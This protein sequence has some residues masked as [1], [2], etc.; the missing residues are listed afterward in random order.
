MLCPVLCVCKHNSLTSPGV[1][2]DTHTVTVWLKVSKTLQMCPLID[3][4][5][6]WIYRQSFLFLFPARRNYGLFNAAPSQVQTLQV[7]YV[8]I[9]VT[10]RCSDVRLNI[11]QINHRWRILIPALWCTMLRTLSLSQL[12]SPPIPMSTGQGN[13]WEM[14]EIL[15]SLASA[16]IWVLFYY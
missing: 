11:E 15:L 12:L 14:E 3:P 9:V 13:E 16:C 4:V 8:F 6:A 10:L 7:Q 2:D 5:L 1:P